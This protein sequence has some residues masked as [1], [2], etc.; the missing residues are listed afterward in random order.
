MPRNPVIWTEVYP[1]H[2]T[3][4]VNNKE[5]F[6]GD[7]EFIWKTMT[8]EL[9]EQTVLNRLLVHA[10]VLMPNHFHLLATAPEVSISKSMQ[11]LM[12]NTTRIVNTKYARWGRLFGSRYH[13]TII[14]DAGYF[15]HA[16]KYVY[17]NPVKAGLCEEVG[18]Y[19]FST[20]FGLCGNG[21]LP[22]TLAPPLKILTRLLPDAA[23]NFAGF[24]WWLNQP[25]NAEQELLIRD[26]LRKEN[27]E[28]PV[29]RSTRRPV[30]ILD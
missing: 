26:A 11:Q 12:A 24:E 2:L 8:S 25:Y 27:F 1:Y 10:F 16:L 4:R 6:P 21:T 22:L 29:K 17:R 14:R 15:A 13:H 23:H 20:F 9:H 30:K 5:P 18:D 7:L 3:A 28:I 19:R